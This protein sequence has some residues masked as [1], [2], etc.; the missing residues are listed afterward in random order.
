VRAAHPDG[1]AHEWD[2]TTGSDRRISDAPVVQVTA[3]AVANNGGRAV[4]GDVDYAVSVW[5]LSTQEP[6]LR[7]PRQNGVVTAVAISADG[8]HVAAACATGDITVWHVESEQIR[9]RLCAERFVSALCLTPR[10]DRVV[11]GEGDSATVHMVTDLTNNG[12]AESDATD[13]VVGRL[14]TRA[15]VTALAAN[16]AMP[17]DILLGTANGQVAYIRVP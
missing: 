14:A 5:D 17:C 3:F 6:L 15:T 2:L 7:L 9:M 12:P 13:T 10:G 4:T 1:T 11:L 8:R 16:P